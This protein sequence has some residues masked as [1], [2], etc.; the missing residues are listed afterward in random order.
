MLAHGLA[1]HSGRY[2]YVAEQLNAAGFAVDAQRVTLPVTVDG[3][4][5]ALVLSLAASGIAADVAALDE[6]RRLALRDEVARLT[7]PLMNGDVIRDT[8]TAWILLLS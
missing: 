4:P 1:E 8:M 7:Q 2:A 6:D 5:D 3:G